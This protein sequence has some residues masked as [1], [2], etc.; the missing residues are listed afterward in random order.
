M[1]SVNDNAFGNIFV[2]MYYDLQFMSLSAKLMKSDG[3]VQK[4]VK[5]GKTDAFEPE[6]GT[7]TSLSQVSNMITHK[8]DNEFYG[9]DGSYLEAEFVV[10]RSFLELF[11]TG[12]NSNNDL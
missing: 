1:S 3:S 6:L 12:D 11:D 7:S 8:L 5:Y 2:S 10:S 4:F 9:S